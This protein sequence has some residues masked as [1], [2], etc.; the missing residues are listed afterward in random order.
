MSLYRYLSYED[1]ELLQREV[2]CQI[3]KPLMLPPRWILHPNRLADESQSMNRIGAEVVLTVGTKEE[4]DRL[5]KNGLNFGSIRKSVTFFWEAN[6]RAICYKCCSIGHDK[7]KICEDRLF[8]YKICEKDYNIN[9]YIYNVINYKALKG[10]RCLHD[11]V[12]CGNYTS[13]N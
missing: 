3:E 12:K 10:R 6:L 5:V 9:N 8:I 2:E 4:A 13:I 7:L 11:L 1:M